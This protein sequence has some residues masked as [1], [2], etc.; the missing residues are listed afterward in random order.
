M[1]QKFAVITG[2]TK[3]IGRAIAESLLKKDYS[4]IINYSSDDQAYNEFLEKN[5]MYKDKIYCI[6]KSLDTYE[7]AI[8]FCNL[9]KQITNEIY[10][11]ILNCGIIDKSEFGKITKETWEKS[12]N[13][14]LNCPF[15]IIQSLS[16]NLK[17]NEIEGGRIILL[18]SIMGKYPHSTSL[19]YNVSKAGV[20]ALSKSLV[21][22]FCEDKITVNSICPGFI[23]TPYHHNRTKESYERI[24]NKIALHRFGTPEEVA[25]ICMEIINNEY[26][27]GSAIDI[28]GGYDYF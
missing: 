7:N 17:N 8:E 26:I 14:N 13:I 25:S 11:L 24:N 3:G 27:N 18:S 9:V 1:K 2:S 5:N 15:Y 16:E 22:Y 28:N 19:V 23:E 4:V 12:M 10:V 6:K 20:I 21:K